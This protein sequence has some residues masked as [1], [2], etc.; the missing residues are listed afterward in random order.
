MRRSDNQ[1]FLPVPRNRERVLSRRAEDDWLSPWGFVNASPWQMMRRMQE[2]MDRV[3]DRFLSG[4]FD[5]LGAVTQALQQ[6]SPSVDISEDAEGWRVEVDLPGVRQEDIDIQIQ[7]RR[8]FLRAEMRQEETPEQP[9]EGQP[10]RQYHRRERRFGYFERVLPLPQNA[11]EDNIRCEFRDGVLTCQIPRREQVAPQSRRIP[12][13]GGE[14]APA[15]IAPSASAPSENGHENNGHEANGA[16]SDGGGKTAR[17]PRRKAAA[18]AE[19]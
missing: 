13:G 4:S 19:S 12:I 9:S 14:T 15:A 6:W 3:F 5:D 11:D 18:A 2:D 16:E 17:K 7:D 10:A 1:D 8:L